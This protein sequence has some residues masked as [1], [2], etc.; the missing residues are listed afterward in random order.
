MSAP[1]KDCEKRNVGC[2]SRCEEYQKYS[3]ERHEINRKK[4]QE[5]ISNSDYVYARRRKVKR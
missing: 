1:C 2:H 3:A 4:M 5:S